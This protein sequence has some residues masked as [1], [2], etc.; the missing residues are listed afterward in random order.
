[1]GLA[2]SVD[3]PIGEEPLD[4][5]LAVSVPGFH[6]TENVLGYDAMRKRLMNYTIHFPSKKS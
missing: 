3:R 1:M 4:E 5:I 2:K 6:T